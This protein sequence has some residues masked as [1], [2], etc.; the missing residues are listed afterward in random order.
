MKILSE[1]FRLSPNK[2]FRE[3][4]SVEFSSTN[5]KHGKQFSQRNFY[6]KF[7]NIRK[8]LQSRL[9]EAC[10]DYFIASNFYEAIRE[11]PRAQRPFQ[12]VCIVRW[13]GEWWRFFCHC[14]CLIRMITNEILLICHIFS[15]PAM[16][17]RHF[18]FST[19][20]TT[21]TL[22]RSRKSCS[23]MSTQNW[24]TSTR[25]EIFLNRSF[26]KSFTRRIYKSLM[27]LTGYAIICP[28]KK[29]KILLSRETP[30]SNQV[31]FLQIHRNSFL[32]CLRICILDR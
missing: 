19:H 23:C 12:V 3:P 11:V 24:R 31:F 26:L 13:V 15:L 21:T 8:T 5:R 32:D 30:N 14:K 2:C 28:K 16:T 9:A 29:R 6:W 10:S 27:K 7:R 18:C 22:Q 4:L 25:S 17:S 20:S 1:V